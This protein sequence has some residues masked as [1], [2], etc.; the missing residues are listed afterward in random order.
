MANPDAGNP[1]APAQIPN[2]GNNVSLRA[3]TKLKLA[4]YFSEAQNKSFKAQD[5]SF[6]YSTEG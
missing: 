2:P 1:G 6:N 4:G 3:E 5:C